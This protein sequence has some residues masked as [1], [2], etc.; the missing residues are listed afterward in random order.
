MNEAERHPDRG[1]CE[2]RVPA[3]GLGRDGHELR[4]EKRPGVDTHVEDGEARVTPRAAFGV[5]LR[6]DR[7]DVGLQQ[8][9]AEHRDEQPHEKQQLGAGRHQGVAGHNEDAARED[10]TLLT[11]EAVG[12]P[13][14]K[15]ARKVT[16][17]QVET[18][19]GACRLVREPETTL[20]GSG[21]HEEDENCP[22]AV[23]AEALPHFREEEGS[24]ATWLAED[25]GFRCGG[26]RGVRDLAHQVCNSLRPVSL[27]FMRRRMRAMMRPPSYRRY[28]GMAR[29]D[30]ETASGGVRRAAKMKI[31]S[32]T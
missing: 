26:Y 24:D 15:Q 11:Y 19:D 22:G 8:A 20:G 13:A 16:T 23:V 30:C 25:L 6:D 7:A 1:K 2:S 31:P 28:I 27:R 9:H 29:I 21:S 4:A 17:C 3:E 32:S 5:Q 12:N 14:T 18:V 10:R